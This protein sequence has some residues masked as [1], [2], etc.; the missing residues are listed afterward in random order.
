MEDLKAVKP[1]RAMDRNAMANDGATLRALVAQ[2]NNPELTGAVV[3]SAPAAPAP[4]FPNDLPTTTPPQ[5]TP[6]AQTP[7]AATVATPQTASPAAST[8]APS[9]AAVPPKVA[10]RLLMT[11]KFSANVA[12]DVGQLV[13]I[14]SPV[15][16]LARALMGNLIWEASEA[17]GGVKETPGATAFLASLKAFGASEY[18]AA[19][20]L[21]VARAV[22][23]KMIQSLATTK[24]LPEGID[25][26][27][28]GT[29]DGFWVDSAVIMAKA[30]AEDGGRVTVTGITSKE[31]LSYFLALGFSHWHVMAGPQ[32]TSDPLT[33]ALD[34]SVTEQIS[35]QRNGP[36]L[37]CIWASKAP[38]PS[39]RLWTVDEFKSRAL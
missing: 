10:Q 14:A 6:L 32:P 1:A 29:G 20:P 17:N 24:S 3:E 30:I 38:A 12:K 28:F 39:N 19:Y 27:K 25:W 15:I 35:K 9:V 36:K 7:S 37:R 13:S 26:S 22:F 31:E 4:S 21:T 23:V 8:P 34:N 11:G 5:Q 2:L 33:Q 18:N 16:E